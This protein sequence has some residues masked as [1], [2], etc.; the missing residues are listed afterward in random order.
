MWKMIISQAVYQLV[1]TFTLYFAGP[2]IL[3]YDRSS[4]TRMLELDTVV[5]NTFV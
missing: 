1:V 2:E 4:P 3:G 5:F